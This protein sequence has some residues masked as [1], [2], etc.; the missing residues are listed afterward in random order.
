VKTVGELLLEILLM[1]YVLPILPILFRFVFVV[2]AMFQG[3]RDPEI[4]REVT[5]ALLLRLMWPIH[6]ASRLRESR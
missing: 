1:I 5:R 3:D 2:V 6:V 4:E